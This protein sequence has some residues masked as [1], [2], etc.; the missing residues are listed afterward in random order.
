MLFNFNQMNVNLKNINLYGS[1]SN[2]NLSS[3]NGPSNSIFTDA[4]SSVN[5]SEYQSAFENEIASEA[6]NIEYAGSVMESADS[7]GS[8]NIALDQASR[9][10]PELR[11]V[12]SMGQRLEKL[13]NKY[14][15]IYNKASKIA[16][17]VTQMVTRD[18]KEC[19]I[20]ELIPLFVDLLGNETGG[21]NFAALKSEKYKKSKYKGVLQ[22]D[23]VAVRSLYQYIKSPDAKSP[24]KEIIKNLKNKYPT[25]EKLHDALRTNTELGLKVGILY[26][27]SLLRKYNG[28]VNRSLKHYTGNQY[29]YKGSV[30]IPTKVNV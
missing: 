30:R 27:K 17:E 26:F 21:Y 29:T 5:D 25:A 15:K 10:M 8:Y 7:S 20:K 2:T 12:G 13:K 24:D 18:C 16:K 1:P 3:G 23:V 22:V 4:F 28:D 6:V 11:R 19:Q 9:R 14:P